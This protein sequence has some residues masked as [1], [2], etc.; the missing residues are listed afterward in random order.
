MNICTN[1]K[2]CIKT[3]IKNAE[4]L[5]LDR[6]IKLTPLRR[7][8]LEL[9]WEGHSSIKAYDILEKLKRGQEIEYSFA[10]PITV[11]RILDL[12]LANNIVHKIESKNSFLGCSHPG[13]QHNCYFII[14]TKCDKVEEGCEN[15]YLKDIYNDLTKNNFSVEHITLEITGICKDCFKNNQLI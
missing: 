10:K 3:A 9:I 8:V 1:H 6:N 14:C 7:K 15:N 11:Y 4:D 5:C 13:K 12:F 2:I